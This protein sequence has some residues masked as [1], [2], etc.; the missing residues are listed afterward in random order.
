LR[1]V[2]NIE[3]VRR[4]AKR[5]LPRVVFDF[6]DGGA[7]DEVT[8]RRNRTALEDIVLRPRRLRDVAR[9]DQSV[10]VFGRRMSTPVI[11]SPAGLARS[12]HHDGELAVARAA[13]R[14]G[15]VYGLTSHS[16]IPMEAVTAEHEPG[17]IW[18]QLYLWRIRERNLELL[19]RARACGCEVLI[20]TVDSPVSGRRERDL[21]NGF[22]IPLRPGPRMALD[23]ARHPRWLAGY[24]RG[25]PVTFANYTEMGQSRKSEALFSFVNAE[26][27][28]PGATIEDLAWVRSVWDG[29]IVVK[30]IMTAEDSVACVD[31]GA[32]GIC[33]STHGARQI[34][35]TAAT[36]EVLPEVVAAVGDR[37]TVLVDSGFRRGTEVV[38]ALSMGARAVLVGRPYYWGLGAAGEAGVARV[39]E[40]FKQEIDV[41]LALMGRASVSELDLSCVARRTDAGL[42]PIGSD[43]GPGSF[44]ED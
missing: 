27:N 34:D 23:V 28:H 43:G 32:D 3:D 1:N 16:S 12:A 36:I 40:I 5:R 6:I 24:L 35:G 20:V 7:E 33:V 37:A 39:L 31:A 38:K 22:V 9:V 25:G 44:V 30:G 8:L 15:A 29:P 11:L 21:R 17:G 10:T 19:Q 2:L 26:L 41:T 18:F 4:L 42:R 14:H 13:R